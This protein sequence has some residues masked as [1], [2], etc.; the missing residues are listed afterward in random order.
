MNGENTRKHSYDRDYQQ[1]SSSHRSNYGSKSS[2]YFLYRQ[3][4]NNPRYKKEGGATAP[5]TT[6]TIATTRKSTYRE[7]TFQFEEQY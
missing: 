1:P 5:K 7:G 2:K 3:R 4:G 6:T